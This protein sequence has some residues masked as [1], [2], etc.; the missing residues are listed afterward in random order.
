[1][2]FFGYACLMVKE[3]VITITV[4]VWHISVFDWNQFPISAF[5]IGLKI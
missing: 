1:M 5:F 4:L 2:I 3:I